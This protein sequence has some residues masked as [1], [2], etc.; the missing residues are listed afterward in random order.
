MSL[1]MLY[2]LLS[3]GSTQEEGKSSKH[4]NFF[5][6]LLGHIVKGQDKSLIKNLFSYFSTK[7]YVVGSQKRMVLL[8]TQ[9]KC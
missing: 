9:N 7:T 5:F 6:F 4:D 3:T 1:N 2:P 8:S